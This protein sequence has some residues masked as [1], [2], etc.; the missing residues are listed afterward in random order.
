MG[1]TT[2]LGFV[3]TD[4]PAYLVSWMATA[5]GRYSM[6]E[7]ALQP[8][9]QVVDE[10]EP[11]WQPRHPTYWLR[12]MGHLPPLRQ[13]IKACCSLFEREQSSEEAPVPFALVGHDIQYRFSLSSL[14]REFEEAGILLTSHSAAPYSM[15]V[16]SLRQRQQVL[17]ALQKLCKAGRKAIEEGR[18]GIDRLPAEHEAYQALGQSARRKR[19]TTAVQVLRSDEPDPHQEEGA[20]D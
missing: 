7:Q 16:A 10:L 17:G 9:Q 5:H 6:L 8:L 14:E 1:L 19:R 12:T 2:I 4:N 13:A 15:E 3:A 18:A 11:D 20:P